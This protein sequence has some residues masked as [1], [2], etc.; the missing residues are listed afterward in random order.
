MG[1]LE[2]GATV[3]FSVVLSGHD[4]SGARCGPMESVRDE[5]GALM[6]RSVVQQC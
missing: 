4:R 5:K 1:G 2:S 6:L 3:Q